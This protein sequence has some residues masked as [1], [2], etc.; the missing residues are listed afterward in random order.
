MSRMRSAW[1]AV[2]A[3]AA[4]STTSCAAGADHTPANA[5]TTLSRCE[6]IAH[7][8]VRSLP[9]PRATSLSDTVHLNDFLWSRPSAEVISAEGLLDFGVIHGGRLDCPR[10]AGSFPYLPSRGVDAS[11]VPRAGRQTVFA[12]QGVMGG[13]RA[14]FGWPT[15]PVGGP[16][17]AMRPLRTAD[18]HHRPVVWPTA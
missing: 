1:W 18:Q 6:Q 11:A 10:A 13:P 17:A 2:V 3:I 14:R 12:S 4:V 16:R 15:Q 8:K 7:S 9:S 5:S